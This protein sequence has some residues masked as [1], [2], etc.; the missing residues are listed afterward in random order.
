MKKLFNVMLCLLIA[1]GA[2]FAQ[3]AKDPKVQDKTP[4]AQKTSEAKPDAAKTETVKP[5][6]PT[7]EQILAKNAEATG[8]KALGQKITSLVMKGTFEMPAMG[9]KGTIEVYSK[10]PN[11]S[12]T[13]INIPQFGTLTEGYDGQI[14]WAQDPISGLRE[15]K[16][17]ELALAKRSGD[18]ARGQSI[19]YSKFE[20][21]GIEKVGDADAFVIIAT[22]K[23]GKPE[24][25]YIDTKTWLDVRQDTVI[26]SP[27]GEFPAKFFFE[28]Y[29]D[30]EGVKTAFLIRMVTSAFTG[31]TKFEEAKTNVV[32]DDAKFTMPKTQ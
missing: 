16:G 3:S 20:L 8:A 12:L 7:A 13:V 29:R 10:T 19:Y 11:K 15:K 25:R 18:F 27:Q 5:A 30:V 28:D 23:E 26:V 4:D 31:T 32:I 21:K 2:A 17:D 6:L 24:T 22:P 9:V 14:G 1:T